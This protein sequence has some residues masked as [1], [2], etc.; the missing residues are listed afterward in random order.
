MI[1][2]RANLT[3]FQPRLR[4]RGVLSGLALGAVL[5]AGPLLAQ[6]D[7]FFEPGPTAGERSSERATQ[8]RV[9]DEP[10]NPMRFAPEETNTIP[11]DAERVDLPQVFDDLGEVATEW[12]MHVIT[13][14]NPFFEGRVP[15]SR[16]MEIASEYVE[17]YFKQYGLDPAFLDPEGPSLSALVEQGEVDANGS[18][19]EMLVSY[20]QPFTFRSGGAR[21]RAQ[22][23]RADLGLEHEIF[24]ERTDYAVLGVSGNGQVSAPVSFAGYAITDGP[25]GYSSFDEDTDLTGRI[26]IMLRY[27][28]LD[29]EGRSRWADRRFSEHAALAPKFRAL[30]Q[31]GAAGIIMVNPPN[32]FEGAS[33]LESMGRSSQ[34]GPRLEIPVMQMRPEAVDR[35]LAHIDEEGRD[36]ADL[37]QAADWGELRTVHFGDEPLTMAVE[38]ARSGARTNIAAEN[39]GGVLPG[40]GELADE[41]IVIGAHYDHVGYG[42]F[43]TAPR[44]RGQLHPGAD[45]NASGTA[46]LIILARTL[47]AYYEQSDADDL[48]SIMFLAFDAEESGLN[49][50]RH[51]VDN[52]SIPLERISAMI[53]MDMI[54]R[55]RDQ[56]ISIMGVNTADGLESI[57]R[58]HVEQ[59]GLTAS[60]SPGTSGRSDD[61][62]FVRAEIPAVH[63]FTGLHPDYHTPRDVGHTVNPAGA[64][65]ILRLVHH[66]AIDLASRSEKLSYS[67]PGRTRTPDRGYAP[68]RLGITPAMGEP[69]DGVAI[70]GTAVDSNAERAGMQG[71]DI[72]VGWNDYIVTGMQDLVT[73]LRD[74]QPGDTVNIIVL[75]DDERV[76]LE[77]TFREE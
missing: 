77:V 51:F 24:E 60:T 38:I 19:H 5:L 41:W 13:L 36:L 55:L 3:S 54:G 22:V 73:R 53:N 39:V 34:F 23:N 29:E 58:E 67:E 31:R 45:D 68:V 10:H 33:G 7:D 75:R 64:R 4:T 76:T 59:S 11:V 74:H 14:A 44:Y 18:M 42:E 56:Q 50:S 40:R 8:G 2:M 16:G 69:V 27:E 63:F 70:E 9:L 48:R 25:D 30:S 12:Y 28:P 47:S 49:G 72:I 71:G 65:D 37:Q 66:V 6:A 43:G 35:L 26:V 21:V 57:L 52:P 17:F 62:S 15:E 32:A 61:A 1:F 20:R 46:G